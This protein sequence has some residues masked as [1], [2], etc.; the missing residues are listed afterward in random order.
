MTFAELYERYSADVHRFALFLSGNGATAD[1][2]TAETFARALAG[3]DR[4]REG[5]VKAYLLAIARNLCHDRRRSDSRLVPLDD[6]TLSRSDGP[7][8]PDVVVA[9]RRE[10]AATRAALQ[11]LAEPERAAL[12]M[13]AFEG[14]P[15]EQI[16]A[17]LGCSVAAVKVRVHRARMKLRLVTSRDERSP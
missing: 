2:V 4:I 10:L 7:P 9:R 1:D 11:Q 3:R 5:T 13:A 14:L 8:P 12:L 17:A 15:H 6:G 16:A